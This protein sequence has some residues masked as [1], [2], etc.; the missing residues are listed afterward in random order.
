M[1]L[2]LNPVSHSIDQL[3]YAPLKH[4][5]QTHP[6]KLITPV[7]SSPSYPKFSLQSD[8][9]TL[10]ISTT[11]AATADPGSGRPALVEGADSNISL[12]SFVPDSLNQ[13]GKFD[14]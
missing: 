3:K 10:T 7:Q 12:E 5:W 11:N 6:T 4:V 14:F 13:R 1:D 8:L 9:N 2:R